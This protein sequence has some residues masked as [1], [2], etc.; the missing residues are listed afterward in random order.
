MVSKARK[1]LFSRWLEREMIKFIEVLNETNFNPRME[2]TAQPK[3]AL[4]EVWINENYVVSIREAAGYKSL[5][6]EGRLPADLDID[7]SFTFVTTHNGTITE[8]HVVVGTPSVVAGR[9]NHD[10]KTLLKG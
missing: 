7:H 3:F 6:R 1:Y 9:L 4:G 10:T 5:L 2:R 8:S